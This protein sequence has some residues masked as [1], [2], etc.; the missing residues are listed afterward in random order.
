MVFFWPAANTLRA[1]ALMRHSETSVRIKDMTVAILGKIQEIMIAIGKIESFDDTNE[2]WET[3]AERVEQFFLANDLD[4]DRKV[5]TLLS[6]IGG[7]TFTLLRDLPAPE[8][9]PT[10]SF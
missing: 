9:P 3:Y 5:P 8:K 10:K 1:C 7:K 4:D 2:K 6:F